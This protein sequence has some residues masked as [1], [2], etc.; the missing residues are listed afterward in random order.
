ME[1]RALVATR[2]IIVNWWRTTDS[3][4]GGDTTDWEQEMKPMEIPPTQAKLKPPALLIQVG[5]NE[6]SRDE[7]G[8]EKS[9]P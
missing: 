2:L 7:D 1:V 3:G 9:R 6:P 5:D 8:E 4:T